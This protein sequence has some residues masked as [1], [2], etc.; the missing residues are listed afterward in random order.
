MNNPFEEMLARLQ[1][2]NSGQPGSLLL[3]NP[4]QTAAPF[5]MPG[6]VEMEPQTVEQLFKPQAKK[7][8]VVPFVDDRQAPQPRTNPLYEKS[9]ADGQAVGGSKLQW[10]KSYADPV[11]DQA[12][13]IAARQLGLGQ[14][15]IAV[16]RGIRLAGERSNHGLR[17]SA[18]AYTPYQFIPSTRATFM[19]QHG[20]DAY[21]DPVSAAKAALI[22][23][24]PGMKQ[25]P[26]DPTEAIA[27]YIAGTNGKRG[28]DTRAYVARVKA[29]LGLKPGGVN[30]P[31]GTPQFAAPYD[32]NFWQGQEQAIAAAGK[33]MKTPFTVS[34]PLADEPVLPAPVALPKR[35]F[36][37]TDAMLQ[38]LA[39][40]ELDAFT[41]QRVER[42]ALFQG[43]A[44]GLARIPEGA[45]LGTVLAQVGAG[46]LAGKA[47]GSQEVQARLDAYDAKMAQYK[48]A[49]MQNEEAK[50]EQAFAEAN[51][52]AG[53]LAAYN[54]KT[55]AQKYQR[56]IKNNSQSV[57]GNYMVTTSEVDG[58]LATKFTPL[59]PLIDAQIAMQQAQVEGTKASAQFQSAGQV[60]NMANE[61]VRAQFV[62]AAAGENSM[63]EGAQVEAVT[64]SRVWQ[65][66][67]A[68]QKGALPAILGQERYDAAVSLAS[69]EAQKLGHTMGSKEYSSAVQSKL[70]LVALEELS[71][72]NAEEANKRLDAYKETLQA[73]HQADRFNGKTTS[74]KT[75]SGDT[76]VTERQ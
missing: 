3:K 44:A 58:K 30:N 5:Q 34:S 19:Q 15:Y 7:K 54:D 51:A 43:I 16:V 9:L 6:R 62:A 18:G 40:E 31:D 74:T 24:M 45:G 72:P 56:F 36:S 73:M 23:L 60:T 49:L 59:N 63:A 66:G 52:E 65:V 21:A 28:P 10:A 11:Y 12:E 47:A 25:T 69:T 8:S 20:V 29:Y 61:V 22:H 1:A 67:E 17:S 32:A 76:T 38:E 14:D 42:A 55:F 68:V 64:A 50:A 39:P 75:R 53:Q 26:G 37:K 46:M 48:V 35:D 41:G 2:A 71:K 33:A 57:Q 27:Q 70:T 13:Q 4:P